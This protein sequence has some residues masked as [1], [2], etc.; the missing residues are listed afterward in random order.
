M[1]LVVAALVRD[2]RVTATAV[3]VVSTASFIVAAMIG[4]TSTSELH[5]VLRGDVDSPRR[6]EP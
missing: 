5:R 2:L 4:D 6:G 1:I 3:G